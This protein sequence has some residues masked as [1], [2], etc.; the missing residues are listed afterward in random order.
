MKNVHT[1]QNENNKL[2]LRSKCWVFALTVSIYGTCNVSDGEWSVQSKQQKLV[3]HFEMLNKTYEK[4][5]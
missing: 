4:W 3:E 5:H 1:N 2:K